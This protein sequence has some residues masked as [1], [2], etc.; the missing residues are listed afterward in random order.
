MRT[1]SEPSFYIMYFLAALPF[2]IML[3]VAFVLAFGVKNL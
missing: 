1:Y 3:V 2:I